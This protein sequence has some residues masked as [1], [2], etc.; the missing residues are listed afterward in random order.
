MFSSIQN[1]L[2]TCRSH[3]CFP[4]FLVVLSTSSPLTN[5]R[6][7][8]VMVAREKVGDSTGPQCSKEGTSVIL[9]AGLLP[10][11]HL[12]RHD[13]RQL[14]WL[15]I[16]RITQA[17]VRTITG[18]TTYLKLTDRFRKE[19]W[20]LVD[21]LPNKSNWKLEGREIEAIEEISRDKK[22]I[23]ETIQDVKSG[24]VFC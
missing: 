7:L 3:I 21:S 5:L 13:R 23:H 22:N 10:N 9:H 12:E 11:N 8:L 24:L 19:K 15:H 2:K 17:P 20:S 18:P 1:L 14:P 6:L 4:Y 16:R